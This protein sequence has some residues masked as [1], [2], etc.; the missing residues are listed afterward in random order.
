MSYVSETIVSNNSPNVLWDKA[1]DNDVKNYKLLLD[2]KLTSL[3]LHEYCQECSDFHCKNADHCAMIDYVSESIIHCCIEAASETLPIGRSNRRKG[4]CIPGWNEKVEPLKK[5][6]LFWHSIW[7]SC[8]SPHVGVV[9]SIRRRVRALY[10]RAI[11]SCIRDR[12][13]F[14]ARQMASAYSQKNTVEFWNCVKRNT[15]I[16]NSVP[17]SV[18]SASGEENIANMFANKFQ[19]LYNSAASNDS[20][21]ENLRDKIDDLVSVKC[22]NNLC[23]MDHNISLDE[24]TRG[25]K[26]LKSNKVDGSSGHSSNHFIH[27]TE[28]L[29]QILANLLSDMLR[30]GYASPEFNMSIILPIVKN[31]K[32]SISDSSNY[33]AIALSSVLSKLC[34]IVIIDK[35][36]SVLKS[37]DFQFGFKE[38]SSTTQCTFVFNEVVQYYINNGGRVYA[39]F[40]DASK[41]FDSVKFD[42]MFDLLLQKG[43]CPLVARFLVYIYLNQSCCVKWGSSNSF[44]FNIKNG[45]KQGGILSPYLFNLYIDIL[46]LQL[47]KCGYGCHIGNQYMGSFAYADDLILL[48]PTVSSLKAQLHVC[49]MFSN[50]YNIK[51]NTEKSK[52]IAYGGNDVHIKFQGKMIPACSIENHIGHLVG[53]DFNVQKEMIQNACNEMYGKLNLLLRQFGNIDRWILYH[54]F[55]SYCLSLYGSNLWKLYSTKEMEP[56]Y[57]AWRKCVR[58][59]L[60]VPY[61][62]HCRLLPLLVDD[63]SIDVKLYKRFINFINKVALSQ[64]SCVNLCVKIMSSG[65]NSVVSNTWNFICSKY[66]LDRHHFMLSSTFL[67]QINQ[68]EENDKILAGLIKDLLS[69]DSSENDADVIE[70]VNHLCTA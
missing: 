15:K 37:S 53:K 54:L 38:N 30:H 35:Q 70:I 49:E 11:K 34:D 5:D 21:M 26:L 52:L 51:F 44:T 4:K 65:S 17:S 45:V 2:Q 8:G 66:N 9:A 28:F 31:R 24:V 33:R 19:G 14:V 61:N 27:G 42:K 36:R 56:L 47:S 68:Y 58:R 20:D 39:T 6:T 41:A 16:T 67:F 23:D 13:K 12:D 57:I 59:I 29:H 7:I 63:V 69:Y 46:L 55:N 62:T 10:H 50:D 60:G 43:I 18:D 40:L 64:N 3:N 25:I 32:K 1:T 22:C 48:S